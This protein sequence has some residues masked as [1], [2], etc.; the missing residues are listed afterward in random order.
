MKRIVC[1]TRGGAASRAVQERAISLAAEHSAELVFL[2]VADSCSCGAMSEDLAQVVEDELRRMGRSLLHIAHVR[3]QEQG[4]EADMTAK[5]GPVRQTILD[6]VAETQADA[7]VIGA[8]RRNSNVQ[9]FGDNGLPAFAR[10]V[11]E[12]TGAQVLI[13]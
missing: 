2:Y 3:A 6:F 10:K 13:V 11:T 12:E 1:A 5:C 8:P 4:V 9:E 7:L